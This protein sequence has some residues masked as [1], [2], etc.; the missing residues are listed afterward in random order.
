MNTVLF[1]GVGFLFLCGVLGMPIAIGIGTISVLFTV[2]TAS[3]PDASVVHRL[4][5]ATESWP[6]MAVPFF[7]LMGEALSRGKG[8]Q[9]MMDLAHE[10]VGW[11]W[12]GLS[13]VMVVVNMFLGGCS[14]SAVA[15]AASVGGVLIP[16]MKRRHYGAGYAA[17]LNATAST[18]GIIIPPSIPMILFA[19]VTEAS[20]RKLFLAGIVPGVLIGVAMMGIGAFL[21]K[22]YNHYR[23]PKPQKAVVM[24][25]TVKSLPALMI[26][27]IVIGGILTGVFTTTEAAIIGAL[28][29][30]IIEVCWYRSYGLRAIWEMSVEAA[31]MTGG[32]ILLI[33]TSFMLTYLIV[34]SQVPT[35][36]QGIMTAHIPGP[37]SLLLVITAILLVS[38]CFLDLSPALLI[39]T[40]IFAPVAVAMGVDLIHLGVVMTM[41]LGIGLV[42]PPVGQTLFISALIAETSIEDVSRYIL[43]FIGSILLIVLFVIFCPWSIM[44]AINI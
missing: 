22:K 39:F 31:K 24:G 13:A 28:Y 44:W 17:A 32:V 9:Y 36:L 1:L 40:P 12:G 19:W 43:P 15:D 5:L 23:A 27:L 11:F 2:V 42:T 8:G 20:I 4:A 3:V 29:V 34:I 10:L 21:G 14:G 35:M 37:T 41:V 26:P 7:M 6:L 25:L 16:E 38:G 18:I 33:A 30:L